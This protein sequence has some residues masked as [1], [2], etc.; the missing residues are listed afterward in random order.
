MLA[1]SWGL[2][3][4]VDIRKPSLQPQCY[5]AF[6]IV[7]PHQ[8]SWKCLQ[9]LMRDCQEA[10]EYASLVHYRAGEGEKDLVVNSKSD[11]QLDKSGRF[12]QTKQQLPA[13][14]VM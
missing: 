11:A 3:D 4:K 12:R 9:A 13:T 2:S 5:L 8:G 14:I 10:A 1:H 6:H 7:C